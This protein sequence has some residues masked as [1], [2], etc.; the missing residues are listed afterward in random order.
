MLYS[1]KGPFEALQADI[2]DIRFLG[3]L[4][5][6]P[7]YYLLFV[8]LFTSMIYTYPMRNHKLLAKKK[9]LQFY[10]DIKKRELGKLD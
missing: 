1:F 10:Q 9:M 3:K 4:T 2:A 7:K 8:D 6:D 5:V